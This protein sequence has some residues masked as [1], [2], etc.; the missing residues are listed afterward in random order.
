M[1]V[2]NYLKQFQ[3]NITS[4]VSFTEACKPGKSRCVQLP[5]MSLMVDF[6]KG[7]M[8][9]EAYWQYLEQINPFQKLKYSTQRKGR[10]SLKSTFSASGLSYSGM[11]KNNEF[12][13]T[14]DGMLTDDTGSAT[15]TGLFFLEKKSSF[16]DTLTEFWILRFYFFDNRIDNC[17]INFSLPL[18]LNT[19]A[20][21]T[22]N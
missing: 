9:L 3:I 2:A 21:E 8:Q 4:E 7:F 17:E 18:F 13:F 15:A 19:T 5:K 14:T 22:S 1:P 12:I 20:D 6:E 16:K 11:I 10:F